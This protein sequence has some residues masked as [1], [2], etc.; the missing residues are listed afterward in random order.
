M[1][2]AENAGQGGVEG[3]GERERDVLC[4]ICPP[5]IK[6]S[7]AEHAFSGDGMRSL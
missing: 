5:S 3:E 2:S 7:S 4:R 1:S 6:M